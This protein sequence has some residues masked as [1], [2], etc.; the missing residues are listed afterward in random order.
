M[1]LSFAVSVS[2]R[3]P[4]RTPMLRMLRVMVVPVAATKERRA[5]CATL[6]LPGVTFARR[7]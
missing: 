5:T 1:A 7:G 3:R 2:W 6:T 4:P